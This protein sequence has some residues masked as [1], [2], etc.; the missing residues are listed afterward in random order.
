MGSLQ[1]PEII[2]IQPFAWQNSRISGG[3]V[4]PDS[5]DVHCRLSCPIVLSLTPP[6]TA[7]TLLPTCLSTF[8]TTYICKTRNTGRFCTVYEAR[9]STASNRPFT[10]W[11]ASDLRL[12]LAHW[13]ASLAAG[14]ISAQ[15]FY[16]RPLLVSSSL[17]TINSST[18]ER[19]QP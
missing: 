15:G 11:S 12:L 14:R 1:A 5:G 13:L 18:E 8:L 9:P 2:G 10:I 16:L 4:L 6:H 7:Q 3:S 19:H 17:L